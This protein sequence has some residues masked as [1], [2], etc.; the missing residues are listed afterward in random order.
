MLD[1]ILESYD[2]LSEADKAEVEFAFNE[3]IEVRAAEMAQDMLKENAPTALEKVA[4][5]FI[6]EN[7][8]ALKEMS[9]DQFKSNLQESLTSNEALAEKISDFLEVALDEYK[10]EVNEKLEAQVDIKRAE[11]ISEAFDG[12]IDSFGIE[13]DNIS[14]DNRYDELAAKYDA[15]L[16]KNIELSKEIKEL[17]KDKMIAEAVDKHELNVVEAEKFRS[18]VE[19]VD[20]NER[21]EEKIARIAETVKGS[22][23]EKKEDEDKGG[24]KE[25]LNEDVKDEND[26]WNKF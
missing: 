3:Q 26:I 14:N 13:V 8:E 17:Q 19:F 10:E 7:E 23:N 11:V 24:S 21:A 15:E 1:K 25:S 16:A 22:L 18:M 6:K 2:R 20:L 5:D 12:M 9:E 4:L